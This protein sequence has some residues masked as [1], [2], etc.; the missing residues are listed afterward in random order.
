[1]SVTIMDD[2]FKASSASLKVSFGNQNE[3]QQSLQHISSGTCGTQRLFQFLL[4]ENDVGNEPMEEL[5][6]CRPLMFSF[7]PRLGSK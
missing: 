7:T 2:T 5:C 6:W 1:M 3:S 4:M